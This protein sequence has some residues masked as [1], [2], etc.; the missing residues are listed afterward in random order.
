[1]PSSLPP[2]SPPNPRST[3]RPISAFGRLPHATPALLPGFH[4]PETHA[5]I[6]IRAQT[7]T[8]KR[9]KEKERV[10]ERERERERKKERERER[11]KGAESS[12]RSTRRSKEQD[13]SKGRRFRKYATHHVQVCPVP[14]PFPRC[15]MARVE[16]RVT[17]TY[18]MVHVRVT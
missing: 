12:S 11:K 2:P 15:I 9:V 1:M 7:P 8:Q 18:D 13:G 4:P 10:R 3:T 6:R 17:D 5:R 16:W 14:L